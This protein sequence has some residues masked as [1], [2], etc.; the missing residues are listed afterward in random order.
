MPALSSAIRLHGWYKRLDMDPVCNCFQQKAPLPDLAFTL[1]RAS[2]LSDFDSVLIKV[3]QPSS[4][5]NIL[6]HALSPRATSE[7]SALEPVLAAR[8]EL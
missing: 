3:A 8:S 5:C 2:F 7:G 6:R 1:S 4:P